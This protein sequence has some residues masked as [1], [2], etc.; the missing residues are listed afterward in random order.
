MFQNM[1]RNVRKRSPLI[2][3]ITNYVTANELKYPIVFDPVGVGA[4]KRRTETAMQLLEEVKFSVIR[5]N[6]SEIKVLAF[7]NGTTKGVDAY[8]ADQVMEE[9][10]DHVIAFAKAFA[11]KTISVIAITGAIDI[12]TDGE[13]NYCIRN[14]HPGTGV[15]GV[16]LIS[17]IFSANNIENERLLLRKQSEERVNVC[18]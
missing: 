13:K 7:G 9:N 6:I 2:H 8:V 12:V 4:S 18:K 14:G 17:A 16:A 15:A 3:N 1:L 5:G 10:L 11:K